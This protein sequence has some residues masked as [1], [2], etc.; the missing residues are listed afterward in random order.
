MPVLFNLKCVYL[1]C[2]WSADPNEE[3]ETRAQNEMRDCD[4]WV[5]APS[6]FHDTLWRFMV[7]KLGIRRDAAWYPHHFGCVCQTRIR[8]AVRKVE[9]FIYIRLAD[10]YTHWL[11]DLC[12]NYSVLKKGIICQQNVSWHHCYDQQFTRYVDHSIIENRES[13]I[14]TNSDSLLAQILAQVMIYMDNRIVFVSFQIG[15]NVTF[16]RTW[17]QLFSIDAIRK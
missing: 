6:V 16:S 7:S 11:D 17:C 5:C 4:V 8:T 10:T 12:T 2:C 1:C 13:Y 14:T 9:S 3:E 15:T